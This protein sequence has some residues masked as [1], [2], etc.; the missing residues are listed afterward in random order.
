MVANGRTASCNSRMSPLA[1]AT[2]FSSPSSFC[3]KQMSSASVLEDDYNDN[4]TT[5]HHFDTKGNQLDPHPLYP[6]LFSPLD[7]GP[8]GVLPNRALMGSMHTGLEGHSIPKWIERFALGGDASSQHDH[9][10]ERMAAYFEARA[11]GGMG[12]MVTGGIAPNR[13]GWVG[14]FA[15]KLTTTDEQNMHRVVTDAVHQ[16]QVP[17]F[18][19]PVNDSVASKICLQILHTGRYAYH[20]FAVSAS[21]TKSPI[22]PFRARELST[23]GVQ[24]TVDDFTRTAVLAQNAGYDGVEVM[25]SEGYLLSQFLSPR[26]NMRKDMYG[27]SFANRARFP[28]DI[29]RSIRKATSQ[30]FIVIFRISLLDLVD[31]GMSWE[32]SLEL[33]SL[34]EQAGV[35]ILNT[36]IG[37]HESRVP[38]IATSVPRGAFTFCTKTLRDAGVVSIPLISTNRINAPD[39]AESILQNEDSD[40]IS[41]ARPLLA[42]PNFMRK[43]MDQRSDHINTCIG[44]NQACLDHAFVGKT[45][46]CLVNPEACHETELKT[47]LLP[48]EQRL[49]LNV[50]G[51]GPAGCAFAIAA[52]KMG[53]QVTLYDKDARIGGQFHMAKRIPGKEEF[54]ETLRYFE[55]ELEANNVDVRLNTV[56]S[57]DDMSHANSD[58]VDKWIVATGVNPR[59]PKIPGM[60]HPNVL[61]YIDVLKHKK[62]VGE[63]VAII[64]AGGIGFDVAEFLLYHDGQDRTHSDVSVS[65]FWEEWGIDPTQ[66][67]RGGLTGSP[68]T[69]QA[70]RQVHLMQRKK[71]K[72]GAGL[73]RTTGWIHR[74][75]LK[76]GNVN[77][78]NG[79]S[80]DSIDENG[81]LH[82]TRNGKQEVLEVDNIIMCAG[83]TPQRELHDKAVEAAGDDAAD[84]LLPAKVYTI[85]GAFEAGELDAKRAIDMGTRLALRIHE[86]DVVPGKH[87]FQSPKSS[88]EKL[89]EA[90][91]KFM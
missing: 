11:K 57:Y 55:K 24:T 54:H 12:I 8:S 89:F 84:G 36:G 34:L 73:G 13:A 72:L 3:R 25:G 42:D 86:A 40:M 23:S 52:S 38:T 87:K 83:Q 69:A 75:T 29:V 56:I 71:G 10:L 58:G 59:D 33:A 45:A 32:E 39:T 77:M 18:G 66:K 79:V 74:A 28:L 6:R 76:M 7:L 90:M 46:S 37:W 19:S 67:Q 82:F 31:N 22:S 50:V 88:E 2:S 35:T 26:T 68:P 80:Y 5:D 60:D 44:C 91:R 9:N 51:A 81:H 78:I 85:G 20:P 49:K 15:A 27:G 61:T 62:P 1:T 70:K 48:E 21:A 65:H 16:V 14:A 43:S 4:H 63:R 17:I 64:G 53:H 47:T 41:M 30:D